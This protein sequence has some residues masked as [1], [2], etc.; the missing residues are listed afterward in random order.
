MKTPDGAHEIELEVQGMTWMGWEPKVVSALE[1]LPGVK[2]AF[3]SYPEKKAIVSYD[4]STVSIKKI[5]QTFLKAGY[6]AN[7]KTN[8]K[9]TL[10]DISEKPKM[11]TD[12]KLDDL[13]CYCFGYTVNDIEQDFIK[14]GRSLVIEKIAA[15][16][17]AGG[18]DCANKNPKGRWCLADVRQVV[19]K[20]NGKSSFNMIRW[21]GFKARI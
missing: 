12:H 13:I 10:A 3:A 18:C 16:K 9:T 7:L 17:K 2:K 14:N 8:K 19:D 6:V 1:E 15:E 11:K 20:L 21:K 5:C 4:K